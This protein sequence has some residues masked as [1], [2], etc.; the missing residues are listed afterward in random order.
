MQDSK[1]QILHRLK[2]TKGHIQKVIDMVESD[3]YCIDVV[4]QSLAVQSALK[5][6]DELVIENHMKNCVA[7]SIKEGRANTAISEIMDVLKKK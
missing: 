4:H 2:I 3:S 6:V 1:K 5:K 7:K